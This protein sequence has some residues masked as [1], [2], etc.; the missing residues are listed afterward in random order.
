MSRV[1][2][3]SSKR[4]NQQRPISFKLLDQD[5]WNSESINNQ[6]PFW[7]VSKMR[8]HLLLFSMTFNCLW[9]AE[10][11][12][13]HH[14][15]QWGEI[16]HTI[17][18]RKCLYPSNKQTDIWKQCSAQAGVG[19]GYQNTILEMVIIFNWCVKCPW[20]HAK[21]SNTFQLKFKPETVIIWVIILYNDMRFF[22]VFPLV[23]MF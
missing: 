17:L 11:F 10:V 6:Q 4:C 5:M 9:G 23:G 8:S 13:F 16:D 7:T 2:P 1:F 18:E 20:Y 21:V 19:S 15:E 22:I 12:C 14:M 3:N